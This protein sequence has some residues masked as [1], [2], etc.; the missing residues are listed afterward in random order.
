MGK[1]LTSWFILAM[2]PLALM[3]GCEMGQVVQGRVIDFN[4]AKQTVTFIKDSKG[5]AGKP[6]YDDKNP[7]TYQLPKD[8]KEMGPQ[9]K[10]GKRMNLNTEKKE[11]TFF[12][13]EVKKDF[14]TIKYTPIS[15]DKNVAK[16]DPRVPKD[17]N[18][19]PVVKVDREKKTITI[20]SGRQKLLVTFQVPEEYLKLPEDTWEAG[21]EVRIYYKEPGKALRVMNITK[22]DIF[23]K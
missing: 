18:Q 6:L 21:H 16:G 15:E 2:V 5:D 11:I 1:R 12:D 20:Y 3:C 13:P 22:T 10:A 8:D 17:A 7:V 9:P 23:K 19:E 4:D 14:V